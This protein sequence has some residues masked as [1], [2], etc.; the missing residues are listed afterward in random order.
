MLQKIT[1]ICEYSDYN[2]KA[3]KLIK[4]IDFFFTTETK[5]FPDT[6]PIRKNHDRERDG[7]VKLSFITA[8]KIY[9]P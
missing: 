3:F 6:I 5:P 1:L 2:Y 9:T 4:T 8:L 7:W